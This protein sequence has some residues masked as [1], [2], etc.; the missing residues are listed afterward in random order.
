MG[1][2]NKLREGT[3]TILMILVFA[4]I[5]TIVVDWGMGG[6]KRN[7]PQGVIASVNGNEIHYEEFTQRYQNELAQYRE[8]SGSDPE[9][10]QLQ[11]IEN[12]VFENL[13]QQRL[14][15]DV[16]KKVHLDAS[17]DEILEEIYN[18]PPQELRQNRVFQDSTGAFD[19]K[20]YQ[21]ALDNPGAGQFWTAVE[22]YLRSSLPMRKL[23][24]FI[25]ASAVVTEDDARQEYM[26]RNLKAKV[27]YLL[28]SA[29]QYAASAAAPSENEIKKYYDENKSDYQQAEQRIIDYVLLEFKATKADS[30]TILSQAADIL[31]EAKSG[32]DF[33]NLAQ[34]YSQDA[35]S[36]KNG[37]DLGWFGKGQ[38]VKPF[39]EA[40]FA[41]AKGEIV[42]PIESQFGVHIIKVEDKRIENKEPQV[43][44]KHILL[45]YEISPKTR[46]NLREEAAY[47]AEA[48][49]ESNLATIAKAEKLVCK[50]SQPFFSGGFIPEV[51]M[52]SRVNNFVFRSKKGTVS[53]VFQIER[54]YLV[55]QVLDILPAHVRSLTEVK[56]QIVNKL[57][58]DK[59]MAVAREKCQA[60][61]SRAASAASLAAVA[62]ENGLAVQTTDSF[63][64]TGYVPN[65][66]KEPAF[67][68]AAFALKP[69]QVSKPVEGSRGYF[70]L[71]LIEKS[72]FNEQEF[73][74]QKENLKNQIL[75]RRQQSM[76]GQWYAALKE[77]S[78]IKDFRKDYL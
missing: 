69:G 10:Y 51:G 73:A 6:L 32:T 16:V 50:R 67:V 33:A 3:K 47:L 38:M 44:A 37:G 39:E 76:F 19:M 63:P 20:S 57:K 35:G 74:S 27:E 18:N 26:K 36:A 65:I 21:A 78:K 41:A 22:D 42:G 13:V 43:Q 4:F 53:D 48:A 56:E 45:K 1:M 58:H 49:K 71:R 55:L 12:Q 61:Y 59:A 29:D 64:M 46:E 30:E 66:G 31:K 9:G 28:F 70:L 77:K 5:A 11:Q 52:E 34:I 60:A 72:S 17:D 8:Q 14:L 40:A 62:A 2:M 68:G 24:N 75:N 25:R 15:S 23:D 7:Q 54:G